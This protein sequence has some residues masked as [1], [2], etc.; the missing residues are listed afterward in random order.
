MS[1]TATDARDMVKDLNHKK[2]VQNSFGCNTEA[3]TTSEKHIDAICSTN[4]IGSQAKVGFKEVMCS[5]KINTET[6]ACQKDT[7]GT[8]K[9]VSC[10]ILGPTDF[11]EKLELNDDLPDCFRCD[12][13]KVNK[14]GLPCKKCNATGKLQTKFFKD[15]NNILQVEVGKYCTQEYQKLMMKHLEQKKKE[16]QKVVHERYVCDGC[17]I[18]PIKGIRYQCSFR[19]N[20]DLCENCEKGLQPLPYPML[21]VRHPDHAPKNLM[22]QYTYTADISEKKPAPE[23]PK[24]HVYMAPKP[25]VAEPKKPETFEQKCANLFVDNKD[26]DKSINLEPEAVIEEVEPSQKIMIGGQPKDSKVLI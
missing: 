16:Q 10:L 12:G 25:D 4:E 17:D 2:M 19:P 20:Y 7:I 6:Q 22:C 9:E 18:G 8:E 26:L 13:S 14:K 21:K 15:L 23:I 24:A 3:T 1:S 11:N 5:T